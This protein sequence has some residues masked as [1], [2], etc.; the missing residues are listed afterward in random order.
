MPNIIFSESSN[1]NGSIYGDS[2]APIRLFLEKNGEAFEA[3]SMLKHM[4]QMGTSNHWA[5]RYA[6]MTAMDGFRPV[7]EGGEYPVD[8]MREGFDKI[9]KHMVWK[10]SF[11]LT[12]EIIDDSNTIDLRNRPEG[13]IAGYYRTREQFGAALYAGAINAQNTINF[14]GKTFDVTGADKKCIFDTKHPSVLGK[15]TQS[16]RFADELSADALSAAETAMQNF[17][18]ENGEILDVAP[19]IIM[20]PNEYSMKKKAFEI[21]GADKDPATANNGFNYQYGRWTIVVNPYLNR[22]LAAGLKPWMLLDSH[23]NE[24]KGGAVWLDRVKLEVKSRVDENTDN[25]VWGGYSRFCAGFND[26]RFG[27]VCGMEGGTQLLAG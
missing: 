19:N 20:V 24:S 5:E 25:N 13:F 4:F 12:R 17:T 27:C 26:W 16:N 23:Y 21:V 15:G 3:N 18:G 2:Q 10:D 14:L 6:T 7:G 11:I 1:V 8:G 9:F 22:Y